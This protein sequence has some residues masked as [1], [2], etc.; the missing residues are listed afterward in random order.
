MTDSK[1]V[2][3]TEKI[4]EDLLQKQYDIDPRLSKKYLLIYHET[5]GY[6]FFCGSYVDL[7]NLV[8][9]RVQQGYHTTVCVPVFR[10][11]TRLVSTIVGFND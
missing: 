2:P 8:A 7:V 4:R 1:L 6:K 10:T 5:G 3:V 9:E 11:A